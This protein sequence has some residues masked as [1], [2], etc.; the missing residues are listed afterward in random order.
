MQILHP[1]PM[2]CKALLSSL[3]A[4]CCLLLLILF[5]GILGVRW[6]TTGPGVMLQRCCRTTCKSR[7]TTVPAVRQRCWCLANYCLWGRF[8][9]I[10]PH[11]S[12]VMTENHYYFGLVPDLSLS[13]RQQ[14]Q[15]IFS[16]KKKKSLSSPSA[17]TQQS[18][19]ALWLTIEH[20]RQGGD[21]GLSANAA[22]SNTTCTLLWS[23]CQECHLIV[24]SCYGK[25][26]SLT[27]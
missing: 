12:K 5:V 24:R 14:S 6:H 2:S 1:G 9:S 15:V 17:G 20:S 4:F 18:F 26:P 25:K 27:A 21:G 16:V 13:P 23:S 10:Y 8:E 19:V 11:G 3:I 7:K 22:W